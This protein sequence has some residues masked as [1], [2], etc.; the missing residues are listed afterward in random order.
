MAA[1]FAAAPQNP[2]FI[3]ASEDA[4]RALIEWQVEQAL[5][6]GISDIRLT[7]GGLQLH[8][9]AYYASCG[10]HPVEGSEQLRYLPEDL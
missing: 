2:S 3:I 8:E 6:A 5:S 9:E 10:F 1:R 4:E 7:P